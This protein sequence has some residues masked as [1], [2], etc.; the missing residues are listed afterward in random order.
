MPTLTSPRGRVDLQ[1]QAEQLR[2]AQLEQFQ[3]ELKSHKHKQHRRTR[4][5]RHQATMRIPQIGSCAKE[6]W[7]PALERAPPT[8]TRIHRPTTG[9]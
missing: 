7:L 9:T 5:H 8:L 4:R 3:T 2:A 1:H 6:K